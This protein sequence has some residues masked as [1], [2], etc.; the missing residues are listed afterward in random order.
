MSFY[1]QLTTK[2]NMKCDHCAYSCTMAGKHG[3]YQV[4]LDALDFIK[5]HAES[6]IALGG[7]E[8]TL[9]PRF[10]DILKK[11]ID[12]FD[13]TWFATNG[14]QT[15]IM[16]RLNDILNN[17]DYPD[18]DDCTCYE[19]DPIQYEEYGCLCHE[20]SDYYNNIIM[21]DSKL[22]V[23]LSQDPFHDAI[24]PWIKDTWTHIANRPGS[25]SQSGY[26]IRDTSSNLV[27]QGRAQKNNL[28][29]PT[30]GCVCNSLFIKLNGD[31][32][33]CGCTRSPIIGNIYSGITDE[34]YDVINNNKNFQS[35]DCHKSLKPSEKPN[36]KCYIKPKREL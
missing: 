21:G 5:E 9:H 16:H 34:W 31:I 35:T 8:P 14:S 7:G 6:H 27:S 2:C 29:V 26:E 17:E 36:R 33:L 25:G 32:K 24:D 20:A 30:A 22:S 10:F 4:I 1:L 13:H 18:S 11:S 12:M 28:G 15:A 19:D 23:A 3:N